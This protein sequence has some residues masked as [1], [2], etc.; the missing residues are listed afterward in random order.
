MNGVLAAEV[1]EEEDEIE[2]GH[3]STVFR[4]MTGAGIDLWMQNSV[5]LK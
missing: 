2:S 4:E 3:A 5:T 1:V